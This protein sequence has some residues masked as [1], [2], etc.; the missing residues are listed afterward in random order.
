MSKVVKIALITAVVFAVFMFVF[1]QNMQKT[2]Q[3]VVVEKDIP[4]GTVISADAVRV[5]NM[6]A[7]VVK[8]GYA[9][10][11]S[12]VVGKVVKVGRVKGD[13]IPLEVLASE[14][15]KSLE[16]GYVIITVPVP[17]AD[18]KPVQA[19]STVSFIVFDQ[20]GYK[21]LDGFKVVSVLPG[22]DNAYLIL[23]AD[24]N[25]AAQLAPYI[26]LN[27]YKVVRR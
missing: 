25:S 20:T 21:V 10:R 27:A 8:A 18:A 11:T 12:D 15:S 17:Q 9:K 1:M 2:E 24:I 13:F 5:V 7:S 19:G 23:E 6:P 4:A 14:D 3:V 26:K 16:P 22:S